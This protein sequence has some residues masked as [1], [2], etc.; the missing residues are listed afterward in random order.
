MNAWAPIIGEV[1]VSS[2]Y[3]DAYKTEPKKATMNPIGP[4]MPPLA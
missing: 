1:N 3:R 2:N 4:R